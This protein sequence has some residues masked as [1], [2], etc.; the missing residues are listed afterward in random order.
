MSDADT[1]Y[2]AA[3]DEIARVKAA[4]GTE[5]RLNDKAFRA[6]KVLPPEIA[7]L[8]ALVRLDLDQTQVA[9]LTPLRNL[10]ALHVLDLDQTQVSDL[11]PLRDLSA[12]QSLVLTGTQVADLAPLRGLSALERLRLDQTQVADLTPLHDLSA[13]EVL[14]LG[15][16]QVADLAPLRD[17]SALQGLS[18]EQT[19]VFDLTP[20]CD[21][22]ALER[23]R[24]D[25]TQVADLRPLLSVEGLRR[26]AENRAATAGLF[27]DACPALRND[28]ALQELHGID[29][30]HERTL[31]VLD[32]LATLPPWPEP[33]PWEDKPRGTGNGPGAPERTATAGT[34]PPPHGLPRRITASRARQVLETHSP[35]LRGQ[36]QFVTDQIDDTLARQIPAKP[37]DPTE[38]AEWTHLVNT[39]E[40]SRTAIASLHDALPEQAGESPVTDDEANRLKQAFETAIATLQKASAYIDGPAEAHG[41]TYAG[42]LKIGVCSA[43]AAPIALI[44]A[45]P[46]ALVG[47]GLYAM[48]YGKGAALDVVKAIGRRP[49]E[50]QHH[51]G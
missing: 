28:P 25:Q 3:Q 36:C 32:Y 1:A 51:T 18:L 15:Q 12:L 48:L 35:D 20:L 50:D 22:S 16:T 13:L 37:N 26:G 42:L 10:S 6:L 43:L 23:L 46:V 40:L 33:L 38:L 45:Q 30:R 17:L 24:L 11:A 34:A 31:R 9:D 41:R 29:D 5:L 49:G 39:L 7:D 8:A 2:K 4:G 27:F 44:S 47:G 14:F 19:Q 21:L